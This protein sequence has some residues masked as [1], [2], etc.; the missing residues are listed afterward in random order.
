MIKLNAIY[1]GDNLDVMQGFEDNCVDL[2]YGDPQF[3]SNK[4]YETF[5]GDAQ[6]KR[7]FE[8]VWVKQGDGRYSKDINVYLNFIEPRLREIHRV[9]KPSGSFYLHCDYH[10][11]A[12]LRVLCDQIFGYGN[13]RS[14]V[15]WNSGSVSGFKSQKSGWI[16]Q[17]DMILYYVKSD[18]FIFNKQTLPLDEKT[19]KRYDK[20]DEN[21]NRYKIYFNKDGSERRSY[22]DM[23]GKP[24][25]D[26]WNDIFS[27][28]TSN[29]T[30]EFLGYP[31]QKPEALLE[32]IIKSSS[33]E[34]EIILDAWA[35]CGTTIAVAKRLNRQYVGI[36]I[37]PT[38][39]RLIANRIG[40]PI[41]EIIGMAFTV[42]EI[43]ALTGY[44][45]QNAVIR[46]LDPTL[47]AIKVNKKGADGGIDGSYHDLFISVKK[48]KAGRK[49]LDEFVATLYRN[50]MK[51]GL[52]I[53]LDYS[54]DFTKEVA[55]LCREQ[56]IT[57]H[58]FTLAQIVTGEHKGIITKENQEHG[59]L[60]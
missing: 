45:F 14:E 23:T 35:G 9:L 50:K 8:D 6:E 37:S 10:A 20:I 33:N 13:L 5:W 30:G 11:D 47:D 40:Y 28:Q 58:Q 32:R 57:I 17:H 38:A 31:T 59:K 1:C 39:C 21:G 22:L 12:Y 2:F 42:D 56:E 51:N 41:N 60:M 3:F 55:R 19:V 49:D 48:Y 52:F 36:D 24:I 29:N 25:S 26:V 18:D 34:V 15:V 16:R 7:K 46:L 44:E 43:A 54:S 53:A 4:V 27:F